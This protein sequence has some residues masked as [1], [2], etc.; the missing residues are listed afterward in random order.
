[1]PLPD[2]T[3]D[4]QPWPPL[5]TKT[6]YEAYE[7]FDAWFAGDTEALQALYATT[8]LQTATSIWGQVKRRF[9]G[10]PTPTNT[11]QRPVKLHVPLAGEIARMSAAL[12]FGEM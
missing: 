9:W 4:G 10:T 11:S 8:R 7:V 1:M 6:A 12:L 5:E 3:S 2:G